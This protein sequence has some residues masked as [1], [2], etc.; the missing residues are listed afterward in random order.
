M[1][2]A[3]FSPSS[4]DININIFWFIS[5]ILS[6][7]AALIGIVTLQWLRE[8]QRY[9]ASL[10]PQRKMAVLHMRLVS[11]GRW[12]VRRVFVGLPLLLQG[13]LILFFAG[14][15]EFL[16]ALRLEV[17]VPVTLT[18]CVP[19]I[20]LIATTLLP[21]LQ[22]CILVAPFWVSINNNVPAPCP[23][24]SP[25]SLLIR[26][27]ATASQTAFKY[28]A[29][30]VV[31]AYFCITQISFFIQ[32]LV[33]HKHCSPIFRTLQIDLRRRLLELYY[34]PDD[35]FHAIDWTTIDW[36]WLEHR[37]C[38]AVSLEMANRDLSAPRRFFISHDLPQGMYD[39]TE[40]LLF[41]QYRAESN[42]FYHCGEVLCSQVVQRLAPWQYVNEDIRMGIADHLFAFS[43]FMR[44]RIGQATPPFLR[45][46]S[47]VSLQ[48]EWMTQWA[49]KAFWTP[50]RGIQMYRYRQIMLNLSNIGPAR[51][52]Q[53]RSDNELQSAIYHYSDPN[54]AVFIT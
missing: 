24:K 47:E 33:Q 49:L 52:F 7:T 25:Q 18:I 6:L 50:G 28:L 9:D 31:G 51:L 22:A 27:F 20:F 30:M 21:T 4:T 40:F 48:A 53:L 10:T 8:H 26:R 42:A 23:Y 43:Q 11:L 46:Q 34:L 12:H 35:F 19:L 13:S 29:P 44:L 14:L 36:S 17:A 32:K 2:S 1:A 45:Q 5:L 39:C 16:F 54:G 41:Q 37:T 3:R 15:I 38:Y